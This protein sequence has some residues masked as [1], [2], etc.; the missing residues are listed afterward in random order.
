[1]PPQLLTNIQIQRY[2]QKEP[3]FNGLY[4]INNLPK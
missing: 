1:M 2:Y 3:K 4:L